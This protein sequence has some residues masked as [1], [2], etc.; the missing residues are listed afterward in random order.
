MT[1][2]A[3]C[4][5]LVLGRGVSIA[6][7]AVL[8]GGR[9]EIGDGT[10]IKDAVEIEVTEQLVIGRH[11][12]L[13]PGTIVRGRDVVLGREFYAN[14]HA[15]I[16]GGSCFEKTSSL[17]FG[18]WGHMGSYAMVNTAMRVEVGDE[19]GMGRFT[20]IY[21]HG[22]YLSEID[23]FPVSFGPVIL[24]SRVWLPSATV[25]PGV[26]IGND[27]VVGVGSIVTKDLPDGCLA[28]GAPAR[29]KREL[30][31]EELAWIETSADHYV[32]LARAYL[33]GP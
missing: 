6:D 22:A 29:V 17:R 8:K 23:G 32:E 11:S 24:G 31:A 16:G 33:A 12:I 13:G 19:V 9:I 26:R 28:V 1:Y 18:Y 30:T 14:H 27:V 21:T 15:E 7:T 25:N 2:R 20:N 5:D 4:D 3:K 10:Q